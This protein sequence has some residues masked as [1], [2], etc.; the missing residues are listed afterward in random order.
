VS[1]RLE[2][3]EGV[4]D[5]I[6]RIVIEELQSAADGL[7]D[8]GG[9]PDTAIHEARKS[10]K[11]ARS[12]LRLVRS[13]LGNGLR[14]KENTAMRDAARHL[15]GARD[16]QVLLQT[17][18]ALQTSAGLPLPTEATRELR[19]SLEQRRAELEERLAG[20]QGVI[21]DVASTLD[22]IRERAATW[23]LRDQSF[24]SALEGLERM[25]RAG[26][27]AMRDALAS[28]EDAAWHEWRKRVKDLWYAGRI[29]EPIAPRALGGIVAE[30]DELSDVLGNHN[31]LAV[32]LEAAG[33]IA[34]RV[35]RDQLERLRAAIVRRRDELRRA[36]AP[37]G[38]RLYAEPAGAFVRRVSALCDA[39]PAQLA[40][41][42]T[43]F[44]PDVAD[45]VR[46]LLAGKD[47]ADQAQRRN[48]AAG[49]RQLGFRASDYDA[50]LRRRPGGFSSEDFEELVGRGVV[51]I[52]APPHPA[53]LAGLRRRRRRRY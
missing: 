22:A 53:E 15:S 34:D 5:G 17:L 51:R 37:L 19:R 14:R 13:D 31:D 36:S 1:Y 4:A 7:R 33:G 48:I 25:Y 10:L 45:R 35:D 16:A 20:E 43:W 28:D 38:R 9:D 29:L 52:G 32:L 39:R 42:A 2:D 6:R 49:L 8:D 41:E 27:H 11:K 47:G 21:E 12:A 50:H 30:A 23:K 46:E 3:R 44:E 18:D 40:A 24:G 26:R